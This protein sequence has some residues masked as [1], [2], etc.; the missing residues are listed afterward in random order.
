[1]GPEELVG[2]ER[3]ATIDTEDGSGTVALAE[4]SALEAFFPLADFLALGSE[5]H[6]L[7]DDNCEN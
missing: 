4:E 6:L 3:S 1:M 7:S 5:E 2:L